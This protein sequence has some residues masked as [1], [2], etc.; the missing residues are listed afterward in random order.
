MTIPQY[1]EQ[2][3][4]LIGKIATYDLLIESM[5]QT[6]MTGIESGHLLQ[7]ELDDGQMKVRSMYRNVKD[8]TNAMEGLIK[9][10]QYYI[11]KHN[12]AV[13]VLRGGNL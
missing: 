10:R 11:N 8:L 2:K 9:L 4:K 12:G 7:W 13:T 5:E 3:S 6:L 1:F